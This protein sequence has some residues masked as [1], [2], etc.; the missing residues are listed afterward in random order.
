MNSLNF[1]PIYNSQNLKIESNN[2]LLNIHPEPNIK[3][4]EREVN[5]YKKNN[6]SNEVDTTNKTNK[7]NTN[8]I[9]ININNPANF[10]NQN[11]QRKILKENN[12]KDI[13]S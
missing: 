9:N 8:N 7:E 13:S 2:A 3:E 10:S 12:K 4:R 11:E 6:P 5:L 1:K